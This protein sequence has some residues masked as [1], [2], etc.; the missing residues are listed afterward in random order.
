MSGGPASASTFLLVKRFTFVWMLSMQ[1][2]KEELCI[3][4]FGIWSVGSCS[5]HQHTNDPIRLARQEV[6]CIF[7]FPEIVSGFHLDPRLAR[8]ILSVCASLGVGER[9][10]VDVHSLRRATSSSGSM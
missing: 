1:S 4:C 10:R 6:V 5:Q 8:G 3:S 2:A 9:E 7:Q